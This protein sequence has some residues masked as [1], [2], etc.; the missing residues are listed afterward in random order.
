MQYRIG[1]QVK[2]DETGRRYS[3]GTP[4]TIV[5]I[6][7]SSRDGTLRSIRI[8]YKEEDPWWFIAPIALTPI[9]TRITKTKPYN[10]LQERT[11]D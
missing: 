5:G 9:S 8:K 1:M 4:L 2:L 3:K 11:H 7:Y 6:A 10:H